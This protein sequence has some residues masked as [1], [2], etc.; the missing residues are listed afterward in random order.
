M[1]KFT[2]EDIFGAMLI[3]GTLWISIWLGQVTGEAAD[4]L[5]HYL[6]F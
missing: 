6:T 2:S 3:G 4:R 5:S 1:R